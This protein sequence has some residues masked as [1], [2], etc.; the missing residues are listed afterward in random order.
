MKIIKHII[1]AISI[2]GFLYSCSCLEPPPPQEAYEDSDIVFSGEL[3]NIILD[4][5][6][7]YYEVTFQII[8]IWKGDDFEE[9]IILTETSSD[10][11]GYDFQINQEYLVYAYYYNGGIYTNICT[12]TNL[13]EYASEDLEYLE[14][15]NIDNNNYIFSE[16]IRI[17]ESSHDQKF[18]EVAIDNNMIYLTWVSISGNNKNIMYSKSDNNG[19]SFSYPIQINYINNNIIAYGQSGPK[20]SIYNNKVYITYTDDRSGLTSIYLNISSDYGET[21]QEEILIS[22]TPY[23]NMY[24]DSKV[25][26]QGNLHLVYYN[27]AANYHLDDVRYRFYELGINEFNSSIQLGIVTDNMEPCDCCQ[28]DL[29]ID[30][31]GDVY[32]I[33]RNNEQNI[34]DSYIAV[35]RYGDADFSEYFQASN[36]QDFIGFCPSSGPSMDINNGDIAIAYTSY[37]SQNVYTSFSSLEDMD[38]SNYSNINSNSNSFQNYPYV[39]LE[40]NL[41]AIWVDQDG[42][43]IFYGMVDIE[44]NLILNS[45]KINDDNSGSN[46][47]DPILYNNNNNVLYSFWSDQRHGNYE[48]YFSK[49]VNESVVLGDINQ[50]SIIDILDV[51]LIINFILG[52]EDPSIIE[53]IASDLNNDGIVNIQDVIL[54]I[55]IIL[56]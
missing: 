55:S 22:D 40:D 29:E 53:E 9:I 43:D 48:I 39:L 15:L 24:Q 7:Y 17:T 21:W 31:N 16:N 38:F 18:P 14:N 13:L 4:D 52:Q 49:A 37:N 33:Y 35:K 51:V 11:C 45:Q 30:N 42:F 8:D 46:Q 19:E 41:H 3:S 47:K 20:I 54:I 25:D 1:I 5:S 2:F 32:V 56:N 36:F 6:G 26:S 44:T 34:R 12:R 23:L 50:D 27:Y 28:P 10:A